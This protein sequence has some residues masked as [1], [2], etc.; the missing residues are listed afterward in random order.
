VT[1]TGVLSITG[2]A[3]QVTASASTGAVTL[4]LPQ[5]IH[6]G[7]SPTFAGATF[8]GDVLLSAATAN[9]FLKNT[10]TGLKSASSTVVTLQASNSFRSASFTSGLVGWGINDAGDA[11]FANIRARGEIASSV[12][13][14]SEVS[15]TAG[16]FGVFYSASTLTE[17]FTTPASTSS[18]FTFKAKNSD[19]GGMLFA[20]G[21]VVR[22]KSWTGSAVS[23][24][25][26]TITARTN[27]TTYTTYTATLSSGSTSATF[28]A[29]TAVV[30][31]GPS[32]QGN[33]TLSTD[34]TVGA[35]PNLSMATHAG[36]P[37]SAQTTLLR[38][39]NLN[40]SYGYSSA[41]YGLGVG[42]YGASGQSW[43]T[44]DTTSGLRIGNNVTPLWQVDTSGNVTMGQVA[45][46]SGN[47]FWNNSNNRLEF[48]GGAGGTVVQAYIDTDGSVA[49]AAGAFKMNSQG[50]TVTPGGGTTEIIQ[51]KGRTGGNFLTGE[52]YT[53]DGGAG[54]IVTTR[55]TSYCAS[56]DPSAQVQLTAFGNSS[57]LSGNAR[58]SFV[59]TGTNSGTARSYASLYGG[60]YVGLVIGDT[61]ISTPNA[62]LDVR[63]SAVIAGGLTVDTTTL[64]ADAALDR[65]GVGTASPQTRLEVRKDLA[66]TTEA[67]ITRIA[68]NNADATGLCAF[69][70]YSG[71]SEKGRMQ[72]NNNAA[73][74]QN[75]FFTT[76]PAIPFFIGT[77]NAIRMTVTATG[78]IGFGTTDQFGSGVGVIGVANRTTAPT[79]NP[80]GGGVL[81]VESGALKYRGSSGTVTTLA[82]A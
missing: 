26:A 56:T 67:D 78:N 27:N 82:A 73:G 36:S 50:F 49:F 44:V 59:L 48:R 47:A 12:F 31:Y 80:T 58:G 40:G 21:D 39:G 72:Y 3:N 74:P 22:F 25:W 52:V 65:V 15:A 41:V 54:S 38:L 18:S 4:S 81:Y 14:V 10:S 71:T 76:I 2:T 34:G 69:S 79:T 8:A 75:V 13:K 64:V 42:Q 32:G 53:V 51:W 19:A 62:M 57:A 7:A 46:G 23:D 60:N 28:R 6:T 70:L 9:L 55:L 17:D 24:S 61:T 16:T 45:T 20:A 77:N 66:Y 29:G 11:E 30:D 5:N 68:V 33:I 37:W 43:L 63:G 35:S 1:N